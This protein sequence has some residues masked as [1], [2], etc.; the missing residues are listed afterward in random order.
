MSE[1]LDNAREEL[2]RADHLVYVSLKYTRTVDM[3]RH[4]I[5]RLMNCYEFLMDELL[6]NLKKNNKIIEIPTNPIQK[7]ELIK[8]RYHE[9]TEIVDAMNFYMMM[10]KIMKAEYTK[11]REFR[12]NV[13]MIT[14][15]D[16]K[17]ISMNINIDA[18]YNFYKK[19]RGFT[20]YIEKLLYPKEL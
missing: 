15:F 7:N 13:G 4:I 8:E 20:D 14:L 10:H 11:S 5:K 19:A 6:D 12:R 18:I 1:F 3:I 16:E 17:N 2:K 9:D